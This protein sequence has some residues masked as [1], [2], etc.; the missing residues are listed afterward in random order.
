MNLLNEAQEQQLQEIS[1][2]LRQV[3]QEKDIRIEE[4]AAKTN[5]R[6]YFL[7]SLDAGKFAELPEP[8][9]IQGFIRRYADVLGLDGQTL[10]KTFTVNVE[11]LT[12]EFQANNTEHIK[13]R[14]NIRIPLFVPYILLLGVAAIAL[15]YVL[16]P[17]LITESLVNKQDSVATNPRQSNPSPITV[18]PP[19]EK[20]DSIVTESQDLTSS[21]VVPS[22]TT[23]ALTDIPT[24]T[25][26]PTPSAENND[27]SSVAVTL[28]LQGNS[29]LQVKADGKTEFVGELTKGERRTW[30][31]K[32]ELTVR[33]GNAGA[34]L[35][36]V[37]EKP[38]QLLGNSGDVKEVTYTPEVI[39]Q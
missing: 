23:A 32:Q 25:P 20:P 36:S 39:S 14:P 11:P 6:L 31:A 17:K 22:P 37:N 19:T 4:V 9:Y 7:E 28:E 38:A 26:S 13:K 10:A 18:V 3:R 5:I 24:A 16:N 27:N 30:T 34:V 21:P 2:H 15:I 12:H 35:I 8:V 1:K 29:W 33:S